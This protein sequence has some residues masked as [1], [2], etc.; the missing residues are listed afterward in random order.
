MW[1][2]IVIGVIAIFIF[3]KYSSDKSELRN[4]VVSQGGLDTVFSGFIEC[5]ASDF[6]EHKIVKMSETEIEIFALSK[7]GKNF[8][9][10]NKLGFGQKVNY[11]CDTKRSSYLNA[12][13]AVEGNVSNQIQSYQMILGELARKYNVEVI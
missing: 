9:F 2:A 12:D 1:I 6:V 5:I 7:N 11:R 10:A 3:S 8:V 13:I 4:K